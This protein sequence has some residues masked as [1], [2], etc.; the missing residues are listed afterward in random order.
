[1]QAAMAEV[2]IEAEQTMPVRSQKPCK[3]RWQRSTLKLSRR[4][5]PQSE[6]MQAAMAEGDIEAEQTMLVRSQKP[7][8]QPW[9][10]SKLKLSR[11]CLSAVRSHASS[12]GRGRQW[13]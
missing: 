9:Q 6:A 10:R 2:Q 8:K 13:S 5:C 11:R 12:D 4:C 3:Q 7:C 1:M